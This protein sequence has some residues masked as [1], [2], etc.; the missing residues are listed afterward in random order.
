MLTIPLHLTLVAL[1]RILSMTP[2]A[3]CSAPIGGRPLPADFIGNRVF[4]RWTTP[5]NQSLRI[6]TDTGGGPLSLWPEAVQ[7]LSL[8]VDTLTWTHG[9]DHGDYM[10]AR[11]PSAII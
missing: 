2:A 4:V 11:I 9:A 7:R 3:V 10:M 8:P 6:Y 1:L 5:G